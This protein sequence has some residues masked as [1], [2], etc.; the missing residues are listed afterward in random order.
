M[1]TGS[2]NSQFQ[3]SSADLRQGRVPGYTYLA[4]VL[5]VMVGVGIFLAARQTMLGLGVTGMT[6]PVHWGIYVANFIFA[7][8]ISA[9]G[10]AISAVAH[11]LNLKR[12]KTVGVV[13]E[14]MAISFL[15]LAGL[16]ITEDLGRPDRVY[17]LLLHGRFT[18]P[19]LWDVSVI[20]SYLG[21][22]SALLFF[23]VRPEMV[24]KF[25]YQQKTGW[26]SRV[27]AL[28]ASRPLSHRALESN[29]RIL[30]TLAIISIP[31]FVALHSVTAW[32][33]GLVKGQAGW[34]TTILAPL[35]IV[36]A[37]VC[38][39]AGV[40]LNVLL[41]RRMFKIKID[42]SVVEEMGKY[43][44]L[45]IPVLMY[46]LLSEYLTVGYSGS[47]VHMEV[48]HSLLR[49]RF[50]GIFWFD[51]IVGQVIPLI[52]LSIPR[53]RTALWIGVSSFLVVIGI[54]T[55]RLYIL[56]PSLM[57]PN[58]PVHA[59]YHPTASE[60]GMMVATYSLGL[61]IF[62][63]VLHVIYGLKGGDATLGAPV[64]AN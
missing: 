50:A 26:L 31:G 46:F 5:A 62:I 56:L 49:G 55:E 61:L 20:T 14:A 35:F 32:I 21:L 12:L 1:A 23:S 44:F 53:L 19:L 9:G 18:S 59:A 6:R 64:R 2:V 57:S 15:I 11:T 16:F 25:R 22:C 13:A 24:E 30:R 7:V 41:A 36:S 3:A 33:L 34:N 45:L 27:F 63:G 10:I 29:H 52:L 4:G 17:F 43:L 54:F 42:N 58:L 37:L 39:M 60:W 8:G 48:L 38:G 51:V 47:V 40:I 28:G